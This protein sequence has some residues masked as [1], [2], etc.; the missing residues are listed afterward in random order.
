MMLRRVSLG[1]LATSL[2]FVACSGDDGEKGATGATG[3]QGEPGKDGVDGAKGADGAPGEAGEKG[4]DGADGVPGKDG[5]D[6]KNAQAGAGGAP[7]VGSGGAGGS[8][9]DGVRSISFAPVGFPSTNAAKNSIVTSQLAHVNGEEVAI[10]YRVILRSNQDPARPNKACDLVA[11][12]STCAGAQLDAAGNLMKDDNAQP[13]VSFQNDFS[14]LLANGSD[15]YLV[16]SFESYP[17]SI[18][19]TKLSQ[20]AA[21]ALSAVS[22]KAI[23]FS[24]VDGLHRTCA[25]SITPWGTHISAEEAQVDARPVDAAATWADLV[26]APRWGEIK[27]MARYLGVGLV[28]VAPADGIPDT[29]DI[30][31]FKQKYTPYFHGYAVEVSVAQNGVAAVAKHY[32]MGRMGMELAYVMPDKK[33]VYL[34]DDVTNGGLFMFVADTAGDLSEGTLYAMRVYQTTPTTS[35]TAELGWVNLGHASDAEIKAIL[36]PAQSAPHVT[37]QDIFETEAVTDSG[38]ATAKCNAGFT[39]VRGNGNNT[40][41]ECLKVKTGMDLAASR[42]ETRRYAVI[43]GATAEL[44]KEEGLTYDPDRKRL[45]VALSDVTS[46]MGTQVGGPNHINVSE[47]RCGGVYA[48]DVGSMTDGN[49]ATDFAAKNWYPLVVGVPYQSG[50]AYP[51]NSCSIDGLA[52]PDNVTYL[53]GYDTLIIGEDTSGGHQNDAIWSYDLKSGKL[54]RVMTTPYGAETTS[55]YW[56]PD[57]GGHGYLIAAVQHPYDES[58]AEHKTDAEATGTD[59]YIGVIGPLPKLTP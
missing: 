11:S 49:V 59:S 13:L 48:L 22:T 27:Q 28:D 26:K 38:L 50:G 44:T 55:P 45:Y 9:D 12:P 15:K 35:F 7:D 56:M 20:D 25:G 5:V 40:D 10:D 1:V 8:T 41:L 24:S 47:N 3:E 2:L 37:F 58:N 18:Y 51:D 30:A 54:T 14:S 23:D 46:S 36:H 21:G 33:T 16:H 57:F 34:T 29:D 43:K 17:A 19:L 42:L 52:A 32:A 4:P 39:L 53:P 31:T 6:G